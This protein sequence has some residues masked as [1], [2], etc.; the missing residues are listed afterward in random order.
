MIW[1][2]K[3]ISPQFIQMNTPIF[4]SLNE[5][6]RCLIS[7]GCN[8]IINLI[9][10]SK[11]IHTLGKRG[12]EMGLWVILSIISYRLISLCVYFSIIYICIYLLL[13]ATLFLFLFSNFSLKGLR[14][15]RS[16]A[17]HWHIGWH[18][19]VFVQSCLSW[20]YSKQD[21]IRWKVAQL[22]RVS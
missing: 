8:L 5:N 9:S 18:R 6:V 17:L 10:S 12:W 22:Q 3:L 14:F 21:I 4:C 11:L 2:R 19:H 15:S 13:F 20:R 16:R 7:D 1:H